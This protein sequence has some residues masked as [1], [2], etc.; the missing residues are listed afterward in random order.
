MNPASKHR[1]FLIWLALA[2]AIALAAGRS[3]SQ[4]TGLLRPPK[5]G[6]VAVHWPDLTKLEVDVGAQLSGLQNALLKAVNDPATAETAL[7]EAYGSM[8]QIYHAYSLFSPA[9]ECYLNASALAAKDFRWVYL[10]A[11][12]DQQ[13]GRIDE[14]IRRYRIAREL[15][16]DYAAVS[17]N[18]GEIYLQLNRLEDA[19]ANFKAALQI[20]RNNPAAYYGLG[21][22]ALSRRDYGG[23]K[24]YLEKAL[25][26]APGANRI[27]YP[28]ALAYRGLG[29]AEKAREHLAQQGAVG[30]RAADP[31]VDGLQEL[32]KGE[33]VHLIRGRMALE[34]GRYA[35]AA[36]EFRK[37]IESRPD[38]LTAHINL[39][40]ALT[41]T[42]DLQNASAQFAAALRI[43][44]ENTT[45]H[46]NLAVLLARED[47]HEQALAHLQ[48]VLKVK[49]DD[50]GAR[51]L[52]AQEFLKSS[53][54]D[55]ALAEFARIAQ[56]DPNN[57][58]ALLEQVKLL[59]WKKDYK[60]ALSSLD[61]AHTRYPQKAQTAAMLSYLL[62]ASPE[63]ELRDGARALELAQLIYKATGLANHGALVALALAE[64]DRCDEAAAWVQKMV[65]KASEEGKERLVEYLKAELHRYGQTHS[66]RPPADTTYGEQLLSP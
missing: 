38:S 64:L 59:L 51:Y 31:L 6:L 39:G 52:L 34:A 26:S 42:G 56:A 53:R 66:C 41:Q 65:A 25:V 63:Y 23:A 11:K 48:S 1:V 32:I 62:A 10:L 57:E 46:F 50:L 24:D 44:P 16:P 35:E 33:R 54:L 19:E 28:L 20:E 8:G 29:D 47:K 40:A 58:A 37:A 45:A 18:L 12:L 5:R 3:A 7:S 13:E 21:Q 60:L 17:L 61:K 30:V 43:D 22:I 55:E 4:D 49:P 36:G 9:H 15:R 14:A 2:V 27:H